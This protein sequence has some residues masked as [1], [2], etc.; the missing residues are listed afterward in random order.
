[1]GKI[2]NNHAIFN[3]IFVKKKKTSY[4]VRYSSVIHTKI[5]YNDSRLILNSLPTSVSSI[6]V[7][8]TGR[9]IH[10][11]HSTKTSFYERVHDP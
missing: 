10:V 8:S 5:K 9:L 1:M 4:T 3:P 6:V 11:N 2:E 7:L